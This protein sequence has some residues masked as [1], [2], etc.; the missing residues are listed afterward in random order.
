[1]YESA[2]HNSGA[3]LDHFVGFM[4]FMCIPIGS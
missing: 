4:D 1:M 2:I 3:Y